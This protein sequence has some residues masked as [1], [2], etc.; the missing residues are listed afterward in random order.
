MTENIFTQKYWI[1]HRRDDRPY[2][3]YDNIDDARAVS[4]AE[5]EAERL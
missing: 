4:A 3:V 5:T 1:V 2:E